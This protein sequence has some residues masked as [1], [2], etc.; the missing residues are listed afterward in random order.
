MLLEELKNSQIW[1]KFS[2]WIKFNYKSQLKYIYPRIL[3][4]DL[5]IAEKDCYEVLNKLVEIG[6]ATRDLLIGCPNCNH[7]NV[8]DNSM[9]EDKFEC[10]ECGNVFT[11]QKYIKSNLNGI[12]YDIDKDFFLENTK[13]LINPY[14][15][16][17]TSNEYDGRGKI[18]NL[19]ET[20]DNINNKILNAEKEQI[21]MAELKNKK[22]FI[23]HCQKDEPIV[24]RLIKFLGDIG[25]PRDKEHIFCSSYTGLGI[26]V[27]EKISEYIKREF[28]ENILVLFIFTENYFKSA[29]CLCEMGATWIKTKGHIPI[30]VPPF[31]FEG[32]KGF[33]DNDVKGINII[34]GSDLFEFRQKIESE[35]NITA[36]ITNWETDKNDFI[37]LVTSIINA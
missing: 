17:S 34:N 36:N 12:V 3:S 30:I 14:Q 33:I 24:K 15:Y 27:G 23:S 28:D 16:I 31:E 37:E 13:E 5:N 2:S 18:I 21:K 7:E 29:P 9:A 35:F 19:V 1:D 26:V 32:I 6:Y 8:I 20:K 10:E 22:I 25:V 4:T 11:P